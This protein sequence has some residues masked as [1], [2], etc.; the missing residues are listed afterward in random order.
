MVAGSVTK[1]SNMLPEPLKVAFW[2]KVLAILQLQYSL[3]AE[4]ARAA[5]AD[6]QEI[7]GPRVGEMVYHRDPDEVAEVIAAAVEQ[8]GFRQLEPKI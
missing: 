5:I 8:G 6:Y 1:E 4:R 3:S 7:V 2:A